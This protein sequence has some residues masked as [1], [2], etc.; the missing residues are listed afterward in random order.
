MIEKVRNAAEKTKQF[1]KAHPTASAC[2]VTFVVTWKMSHDVT[3]S[4]IIEQTTDLAHQLGRENGILETM[5]YTAEG[6]IKEQGLEPE[7]AQYAHMIQ[8]VVD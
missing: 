5:L 1:V 8:V 3:M 4:G 2:A 6:F 7:F